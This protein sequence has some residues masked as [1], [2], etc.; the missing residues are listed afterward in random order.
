MKKVFFIVTILSF[1]TACV[2]GEFTRERHQL[3][4]MGKSGICEKAPNRCIEGTS[5]DW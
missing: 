2:A 4:N 3:H 5:I 1:I